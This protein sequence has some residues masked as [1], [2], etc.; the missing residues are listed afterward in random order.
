MKI[1][2]IGEYIK[3]LN[4]TKD[5]VRYYEDLELLTPKWNGNR[6]DYGEK[7]IQDYEVIMEFKSF[8]LSLNAV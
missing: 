3:V 8:G 4:T 7:E 5:T 2:R 1:V 6:K